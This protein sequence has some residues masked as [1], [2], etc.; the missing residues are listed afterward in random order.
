MHGLY[1]IS[2]LNGPPLPTQGMREVIA[3]GLRKLIQASAHRC[4]S[5]KHNTA[6]PPDAEISCTAS[7]HANSSSAYVTAGSIS[8]MK[9]TVSG[10]FRRRIGD[11]GSKARVCVQIQPDILYII[12]GYST[13][14]KTLAHTVPSG[15]RIHPLWA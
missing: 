5:V 7:T 2:E 8:A 4:K 1:Q 6:K 9:P 11:P 3:F 13:K 15:R 12:P 14:V 10:V